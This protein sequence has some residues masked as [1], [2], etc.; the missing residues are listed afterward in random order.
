MRCAGIGLNEAVDFD[1]FGF[2]MQVRSPS[3]FPF[4]L[5]VLPTLSFLVG[6]VFRYVIHPR[7]LDSA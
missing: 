3:P 7:I 2:K 1:S 4:S 6:L 5:S